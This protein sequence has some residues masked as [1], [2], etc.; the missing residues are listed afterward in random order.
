MNRYNPKDLANILG[1]KDIQE[2]YT[3]IKEEPVSEEV[4]LD[5][6]GTVDRR[7]GILT[8]KGGNINDYF[9]SKMNQLG[10]TTV[11]KRERSESE[12][13]TE[14]RAGFGF[15]SSIK[16]EE[17]IDEKI[18]EESREIKNVHI[19]E[20]LCENEHFS[21][22]ASIDKTKKEKKLK[23]DK[24]KE[25]EVEIKTEFAFENPCLMSIDQID[26]S[27]ENVE[28]P[29][30][31]KKS[32]KDKRKKKNSEYKLEIKTEVAIKDEVLKIE[33]SSDP[34]NLKKSKKEKRVKVKEEDTEEKPA[35]FVFD[36][37]C[38][39]D[40]QQIDNEGTTT[41]KRKRKRDK[42]LTPQKEVVLETIAEVEDEVEAPSPPPQSAEETPAKKKKKSKSKSLDGV[43]ESSC[44]IKVNDEC[45]FENP[46]LMDVVQID[47]EEEMQQKESDEI[48]VIVE[49][50]V[51]R[52]KKKEKKSKQEPAFAFENP[53]LMDV[54]EID[55][56]AKTTKI[57]KSEEEEVIEIETPKKKKEKKVK[58]EKK[59]AFE[60]P[61][62]MDVTEIDAE[63]SKT[64]K[65]IKCEVEELVD[66]ETTKK[67][68]EKKVKQETEFAFENP[69]LK[70]VAE[71]DAEAKGSKKRKSDQVVEIVDLETPKKK[72]KKMK[73]EKEE[74]G[75]ENPCLMDVNQI[76]N[77]DVDNTEEKFEVESTSEKKKSKKSKSTGN[78]CD[79]AFENPCLEDLS[80]IDEKIEKPKRNRINKEN[81]FD[82]ETVDN[83]KNEELEEKSNFAFQNLC[84]GDVQVIDTEAQISKKRKRSQVE[85]STVVA[86]KPK[87]AKESQ[88]GTE[89]NEDSGGMEFEVPRKHFG[90]VNTGLDLTDETPGKKR[91]TFNDKIE[92][93]TDVEQNKKASTKLDRYEVSAMTKKNRKIQEKLL[94]SKKEL[95]DFFVRNPVLLF[96]GSNVNEL[97]GYGN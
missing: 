24:S 71:I 82:A 78:S 17:N 75:F 83:S 97:K 43:K 7:G 80:K 44:P 48:E 79:Y 40:V 9:K 14:V 57:M 11:I 73:K 10:S 84:L 42:F 52:K 61:G 35:D 41:L 59:F 86:D 63:A 62:L 94:H 89:E 54:T 20:E 16:N 23:K 5:P 13:E 22:T 74:G 67:K 49:C 76:D 1:K 77:I 58:E 53:G 6:V 36:N 93:N 39:L 92:F 28:T 65:K 25:S 47:A 69:A 32:K 33:D 70:D 68:K 95:K 3:T 64:T 81:I 88:N 85:V 50:E 4:V 29:K 8:V 31:S 51:P 90:L 55:A 60:N 96:K 26:E 15:D 38:L 87:Q 2:K 30:S 45:G 21:T 66:L 56:Q 37:P 27:A 12:S 18:T 19:K 34:P 72:K 46:C 91:V